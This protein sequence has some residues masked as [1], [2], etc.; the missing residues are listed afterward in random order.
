MVKFEVPN[1]DARLINQIVLRWASITNQRRNL[2]ETEM[3]V[4]ACHRNGAKLD[5]QALLMA[6]ELDFCHDVAGIRTHMN[7]ETGQL[8]DCF[9]PRFAKR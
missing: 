5:L 7:R 1:G 9:A 6:P 4:T 2:L 8:K 3:D